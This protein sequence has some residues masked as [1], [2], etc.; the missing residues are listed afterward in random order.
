MGL[1]DK[2]KDMAGEHS[3]QVGQGIEKGGDA[4]DEKTGDKYADKVD[5]GQEFAKG[6]L[7]GGD[8]KPAED[9]PQQ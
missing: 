4:L 8:E 7:G 9:A 1:F 6:K 3:E 2:A 5:Q